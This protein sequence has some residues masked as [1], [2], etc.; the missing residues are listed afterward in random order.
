MDDMITVEVAFTYHTETGD[1]DFR[2]WFD[3]PEDYD[4]QDIDDAINDYAYEVSYC[5]ENG[6]EEEIENWSVQEIKPI[7]SDV[8]E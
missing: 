8:R 4:D 6:G 2:E 5:F 7:P 1:Y 3:V